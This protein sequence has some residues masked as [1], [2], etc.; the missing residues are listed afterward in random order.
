MMNSSTKSRHEGIGKKYK[1]TTKQYYPKEPPTGA[2]Q[3]DPVA[4]RR[5]RGKEDAG[6][7]R[8]GGKS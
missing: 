5:C 8:N 3:I 1:S 7:S 4:E 2:V 6:A